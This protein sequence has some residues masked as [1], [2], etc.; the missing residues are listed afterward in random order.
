MNGGPPEECVSESAPSSRRDE[1]AAG[2]YGGCE[3]PDGEWTE[4]LGER[5]RPAK[6]DTFSW[7]S[8]RRL[9]E[10]ANDVLAKRA[11]TIIRDRRRRY[12]A[13]QRAAGA[14]RRGHGPT[15]ISGLGTFAP[16]FVVDW[17]QLQEPRFLV[18]GDPGEADAS[19]Y[20]VIEPLLAVHDF[21]V[22][23]D[24]GRDK[25]S[26][27]MVVL[28]D[29]IYPAGDVND[30]V[31]GFYIPFREYDRPIYA[32]PG[33]HDWYDGLSGFM[34]HHCA[35]EPLPH[36]RL[37]LSGR[38]LGDRV[39]RA[40]WQRASRPDRDRLAP[41]IHKRRLESLK[42][43]DD[44]APD[45]H[46]PPRP[47][48]PAP[49]FAIELAQ[50][51]LVAIDTGVSGELDAEQGHWLKRVSAGP[52]PKVLLTGKPIWSRGGYRPGEIVSGPDAPE[53]ARSETVDDIVRDPDHHYVAA[54]GGDTHNFQRYP[55][56]VEDGRTIQYVVAGG[57]GAYLASTHTIPAIGH[58]PPADHAAPCEEDEF[59]C[60]PLRGDSLALFCRRAGP[61]LFKTLV[62]A[63]LVVAAAAALV[64][65]LVDVDDHH[66]LAA[67]GAAGGL[68]GLVLLV[69][70]VVVLAGRIGP[71][72][73]VGYA[74]FVAVAAGAVVAALLALDDAAVT[75]AAVVALAVPIA[76]ALVLLIAYVGRGSLATL[77]PDVLPVVALLALAPAL[78]APYGQS[79][80]IDALLYAV[81]P[82]LAALVLVPLVG[83]LRRHNLA[84]TGAV[85]RGLVVVLWLGLAAI[86]ADRFGERW[87]LWWLLVVVGLGILVGYGVPRLGPGRRRV[88]Q[89]RH[90]TVGPGAAAAVGLSVAAL[91]LVGLEA[92]AGATAPAAVAATVAAVVGAVAVCGAVVLLLWLGLIN[93][94]TLWYLRKGEI[95]PAQAGRFVASKLAGVASPIRLG[96]HDPREPR[97]NGMANA[98]FRLGTFV[99]ALADTN[100]PPFYKCFLSIEV[101]DDELQIRCWGVT[102]YADTKR[103]PSLEDCIRIALA[104]SAADAQVNDLHTIGSHNQC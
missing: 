85:Y 53:T 26:D 17:T 38:S 6:W 78:W 14:E 7:L 27:F 5:K 37:S 84:S 100:D 60:Y 64:A 49:Y 39:L 88:L 73:V 95:S 16:D 45:P 10:S 32:L 63:L 33:N 12:V 51:V 21:L 58:P 80:A 15:A 76:T 52:K 4:R 81:A 11:P 69:G 91:S 43:A 29:V 18:V 59:R 35:A 67:V 75:I 103:S 94:R 83:R 93:P 24:D 40:L 41:Y 1:A 22:P 86:M 92:L 98:V 28:S 9:L 44:E 56:R 48:Q 77:A 70:L 72:G 47:V 65:W 19:Q 57:G 90:D 25:K 13:A 79:P 54:I 34:F 89:P 68:V 8:V 66:R 20:A 87:T 74:C 96:R 55:V 61:L 36:L 3:P 23:W 30:Y 97:R 101:A 2:W 46:T 62:S 31:N 99:S 42:R 50:L 71:L 82:A 102:G 104:P